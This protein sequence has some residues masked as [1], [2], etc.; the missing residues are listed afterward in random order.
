MNALVLLLTLLSVAIAAVSL[1]RA[2]RIVANPSAHNS[3]IAEDRRTL[4]FAELT[5]RKRILIDAIR[6]TN[7]DL[8]TSKISAADRD[9]TVARLEREA[10]VVLRELEQVAGAD[11]DE[12]AAAAAIKAAVQ[13]AR[14]AAGD[15]AEGWS[16]AA[17]A[18]HGGR[19]P[20]HP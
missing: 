10:A 20:E 9:R 7:L 15:G 5:A 11:V 2:V 18:R 4:Q 13:T 8:E 14:L 16:P 17:L 12:A 3:T 1:V 6:S 19:A